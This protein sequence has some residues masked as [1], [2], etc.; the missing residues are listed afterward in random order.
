MTV[1]S[2][3]KLLANQRELLLNAGLSFVEYDAIRITPTSFEMPK[4]LENIIITSQNG[5]KAYL[6]KVKP[7]PPKKG[8]SR[9]VS[10]VRMFIVGKKT[11]SLIFKNGQKVLKIAKNGA[12][13]ASFIAKNHKNE[14]FYYFC[15]NRRR[16]ETL[17]ILR[18]ENVS[19]QEVITYQTEHNPRTF[20]QTFD[21]ILFF[22]PSGVE[23]FFK[24]NQMKPFSSGK[25]A[26]DEG[27]KETWH[28]CI[29]ETTAT[30]ARNYTDQVIVAN[31]TTIESVIAKAVKTLKNNLPPASFEE[32]Q[33]G[34]RI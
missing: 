10:K 22:S 1:L 7:F 18:E 8:G 29:G 17:E 3:K 13:L 19:L 27:K 11:A 32:D 5:A 25:G 31:D 21:G 4:E 2:T 14:R 26:G 16:D 24:K 30:T 20:N 34:V 23:S 33:L 6:N 28:F 15:G 9:G 12:E